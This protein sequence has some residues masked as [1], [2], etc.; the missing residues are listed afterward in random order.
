M[1]IAIFSE[2]FLPKWDG[3]ANTLCRLLVHLAARGHA[4]LLFAPAGGP[5]QYAETPVL[6][7]NSFAFPLYPD[8]RLP[9]PDS[10]VTRH[11]AA[12]KPDV[13]HLV[14]PAVL[15]HAGLRHAR[16]LGVPV[17]ASYHTDIPGYAEHYGVS[18]LRE[19][20]WAYFR[21]LHNAA[22]LNLC[23]SRFTLAELGERGFRRLKVWGRGV[24]PE[25]YHPDKRSADWRRRLT[26]GHPDAPLLLYAGRLATEKR[27]HWL[28]A[29]IDALPQA[30]LA[31]VGDGPQRAALETCFAGAPV[32]FTGYLQGEDLARA[33]ACADLFVF[34]SANETFGNVV[35][36][37]M[38]S[39]LPV[40]APDA[41][42]QVDHV[43]TGLNG[44]LFRAVSTDELVERVAEALE[45]PNALARVG[46]QARDYACTQS[47]ER[48]LDGLLG[49]YS[50]VIAAQSARSGPG[51]D[52]SGT[53][54]RR[55][56]VRP[57]RGLRAS[58][59]RAFTFTGE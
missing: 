42:G 54:W 40:V 34:P 32:V 51:G 21:W 55:R 14:N 2:T 43:R 26:G 29:V 18:F 10:R 59:A 19:P 15:G 44:W 16:Q 28:R 33:Y 1:R 46:R 49:D 37:A 58:A 41:G 7:L 53:S 23:P 9:I 35:L 47:W 27:V 31:I 45:N 6:G 13:V 12:F 8:L 11:V 4:G 56:V 36:E 38:A 52:E 57:I 20:L 5:E 22:D 30:R 39:G 24:D 48:I 3:V 50:D 25:L 17:V